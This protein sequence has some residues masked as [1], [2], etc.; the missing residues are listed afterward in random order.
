MVQIM[1]KQIRIYVNMFWMKVIP[2]LNV[3]QMGFVWKTVHNFISV[4][5]IYLVNTLAI[6]N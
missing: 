2:V 4:Y 3:A 5:K 1:P 6:Q